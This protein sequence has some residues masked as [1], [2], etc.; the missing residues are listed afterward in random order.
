[1][2]RIQKYYTDFANS[3]FA[4]KFLDSESSPFLPSKNTMLLFSTFSDLS[5]SNY[6]T[7]VRKTKKFPAEV[8]FLFA[9]P[10]SYLRLESFFTTTRVSLPFY[11]P[12][13][14]VAAFETAFINKIVKFPLPR[15]PSKKVSPVFHFIGSRIQSASSFFDGGRHKRNKVNENAQYLLVVSRFNANEMETRHLART[16]LSH[17]LVA[18]GILRQNNTPFERNN[19]V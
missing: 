14:Q 8:L 7:I 15:G 10:G 16:S 12:A 9:I 13:S 2:R 5:F 18:T 3:L 19:F 6:L 4:T 11:Q 1:M 17:F